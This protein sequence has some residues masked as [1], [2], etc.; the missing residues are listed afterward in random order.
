VVAI[1]DQVVAYD[2]D[3]KAAQYDR[4]P[5]RGARSKISR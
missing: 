5:M 2:Y 1:G 3:W 4:R